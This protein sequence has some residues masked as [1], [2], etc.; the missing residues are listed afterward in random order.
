MHDKQHFPC[1]LRSFKVSIKLDEKRINTT[2]I[3]NQRFLIP[4]FMSSWAVAF[5][6]S[7]KYFTNSNTFCILFHVS[8]SQRIS[9]FIA[10]SIFVH[11][12][13]AIRSGNSILNLS[14][15]IADSALFCIHAKFSKATSIRINCWN[16]EFYQIKFTY[17]RIYFFGIYQ[18]KL[19]LWAPLEGRR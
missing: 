18:R 10:L 11:M 17:S 12:F 16:C 1:L 14:N 8:F 4:L 2:F 19:G 7:T 9:V 5:F 3:I 15:V 13:P 6:W